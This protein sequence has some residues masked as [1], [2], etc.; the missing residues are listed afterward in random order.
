[1]II[2]DNA[3]NILKGM[4]ALGVVNESCFIHNLQL[5]IRDGIVSERAVKD[6][7]TICRKIVGHINHSALVT[8]N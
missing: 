1:M 6:L 3:A 4:R 5:V 2:T 7:I 8:R